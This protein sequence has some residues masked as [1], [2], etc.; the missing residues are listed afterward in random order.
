VR[1]EGERGGVCTKLGASIRV[2]RAGRE[3]KEEEKSE[4]KSII[5][6]VK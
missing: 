4:I 6:G 5:I 1:D 2:L 3:K